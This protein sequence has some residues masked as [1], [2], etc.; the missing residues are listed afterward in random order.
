MDLNTDILISA[1]NFLEGVITMAIFRV[2]ENIMLAYPAEEKRILAFPL[3]DLADGTKERR[4]F[5]QPKLNGERA[6]T[7]WF[8]GVPYLFSSYGNEFRFLDR[9]K[10]E[11]Q[12][13]CKEFGREFKLDGE[14]Y[15]HGWSRERIDS[16][17]RR[18]KNR[19]P[20][21]DLLEYHVFDYQTDDSTDYQ[22]NRL[23]TL[24]E[25]AQCID[26]LGLSAVKVVTYGIC[27][28]VDWLSRC[29]SYCAEGYE[30]IILRNPFA[31]YEEK[32]IPGL[33]KFKPTEQDEYEI[34]QVNEATT[35]DTNEPKGMVGSFTVRAKDEPGNGVTFDVGAGKL[36][37][38]KRVYYWNNRDWCI[39]R[40]L[41]IKH[42]LL[43]T[44]KQV[45]IAAVTVKVL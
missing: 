19:N 32:R 2:R 37:H 25:V 7:E 16:A 10:E 6:R 23:R 24:D 29:A 4:F 41:L 45:P 9:I 36:K 8:S 5:H 1:V 18:T 40:M 38:D 12:I 33:L 44:T 35:R 15:V 39:G 27:G 28:E 26:R 42:E 22:Y 30:G 21:V 11:I 3:L 43:K 17:L 13:L 14:I 34:V 31:S 20:D